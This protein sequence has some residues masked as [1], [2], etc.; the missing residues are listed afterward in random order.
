MALSQSERMEKLKNM[1]PAVRK[2]I[3]SQDE[4]G[5]WVTKDK[6][7]YYE[8]GDWRKWDGQY[9]V[10]ERLRSSVFIRNINT[11]CDYIELAKQ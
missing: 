2:V 4:M 8:P 11:L 1:E 7:R 10:G 3:S 9:K 5:R 6:Y